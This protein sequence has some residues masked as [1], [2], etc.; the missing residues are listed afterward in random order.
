MEIIELKNTITKIKYLTE[1]LISRVEIRKD[2]INE[3]EGISIYFRQSEQQRENKLKKNEEG[4]KT[5]VQAFRHLWDN[6][7]RANIISLEAQKKRKEIEKLVKEIM[8]E[9]FQNLAKS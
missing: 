6:N 4:E 7:K 5:K 2:R 3:L 8:T 9:I 1:W